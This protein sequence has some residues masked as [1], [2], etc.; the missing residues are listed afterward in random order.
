V[1]PRT[2]GTIWQVNTGPVNAASVISSGIDVG[3]RYKHGFEN[4]HRFTAGLNYT[5]LDQLSIK[6]L[7]DQPA[8]T[9]VGQ[10]NG[11]SRLGAGFRHRANLHLGYEVGA[12]DA[13][14]TVRYQSGMVDT[15]GITREEDPENFVPAYWYHDFQGTYS[16]GKDSQYSGYI[17]VQNLFDKQPPLMDQTRASNI[18]GTETAAESY[19]VYGRF[20]Y[21][22]LRV[23]F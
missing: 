3:L 8:E 1:R 19:D 23:K 4:G 15:L 18:T 5:Y 17:G 11:D 16:F 10:L 6:P 20:I 7:A 9:N 13:S 22:G 21:A 14:W 2:P 12:F